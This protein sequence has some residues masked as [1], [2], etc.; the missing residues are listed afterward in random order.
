MSDER[1][2]V[3][4]EFRTIGIL[5]AGQM[6][7]GIAQVAAQAGYDV[8]LADAAIELA[9]K[10]RERIATILQKQ[11]DKAK[12]SRDVKNG[13]VQR[14]KASRELRRMSRNCEKELQRVSIL[15]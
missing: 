13:I 9:E 4:R 8:K 5:G 11:V 1:K 6:G 7:G 2:E 3:R 12:I 10:G 14:I 15:S